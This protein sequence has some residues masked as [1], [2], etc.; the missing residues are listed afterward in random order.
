VVYKAMELKT[1]KCYAIK[2][3]KDKDCA[4]SSGLEEVEILKKLKNCEYVLKFLDHGI[5]SDG[6]LRLVN[7]FHKTQS[8]LK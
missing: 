7:F 3:I 5:S 8:D 6:A 4:V 1:D 2:E